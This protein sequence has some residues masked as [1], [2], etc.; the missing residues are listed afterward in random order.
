[1][2]TYHGVKSPCSPYC[3]VVILGARNIDVA[4]NLLRGDD[5]RYRHTSTIIGQRLSI[6]SLRSSYALMVV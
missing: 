4:V 5:K 3:M 2:V 6:A 1:M